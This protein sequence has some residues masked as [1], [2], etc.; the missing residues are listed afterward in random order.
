MNILTALVIG[1]VKDKAIRVVIVASLVLLS[2]P[3]T[4]KTLVDYATMYTQ[5]R[6]INVVSNV[7]LEALTFL[8][9]QPEGTLL[10]MYDE[11]AI[12]PAL[13]G[14]SV[15]FADETQ[16]VLLG[17]DFEERKALLTSIMCSPINGE[18][19][20]NLMSAH[21]IRYLYLP[22]PEPECDSGYLADMS[23]LRQIYNQDGNKILVY[24]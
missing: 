1:R 2:L 4:I 8:A 24:E 23:F 18:T 22:S 7:E 6:S 13:T 21:H 3:T 5:G 12:I 11:T 16:A 19:V 20:H 14:K 15:F 10:A 17:L 9:S